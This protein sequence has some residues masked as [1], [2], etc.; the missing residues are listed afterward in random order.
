[1][2]QFKSGTLQVL[3]ATDV[4]ARGLD[5]SG[6]THVYNYDIPQDPESYVHRIGRTGRA[7]A[8][9]IS[10]TF[11]ASDEVDYLRAIEKLTKKRMTN[12]KPPT[13][14]EATI[15]RMQASGDKVEKI[16]NSTNVEEVDDLAK[17]IASKYSAEQLAAAL[18]NSVAGVDQSQAK[19]EIAREK[20]L[21]RHK[22]G[23]GGYGRN[24][25][26]SSNGYR[27]DRPS[28]GRSSGG[29]RRS[30]RSGSSSRSSGNG[31]RGNDF[32]AT[33][34][35][36]TAVPADRRGQKRKP[37]TGERRA[38]PVKREFVIKND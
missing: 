31:R 7:G 19:V 20:P 11:V 8:H 1:L 24:R 37:V 10:V 27:S 21:P 15:G 34:Y 2:K 5:I 28:G 23:G 4:A 36:R 30:D 22:G 16:L 9:G 25:S 35:G 32:D 38:A 6:V 13:L 26:R 14:Q 18:I 17:D 29:G 33:Q 3:V 12:M